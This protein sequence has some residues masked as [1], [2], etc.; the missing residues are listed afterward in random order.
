[1]VFILITPLSDISNHMDW[2]IVILEDPVHM[3]IKI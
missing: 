3:R 1:M 2:G